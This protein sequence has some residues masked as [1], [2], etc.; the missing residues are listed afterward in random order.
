MKRAAGLLSLLHGA[1]S[2]EIR[3]VLA[4]DV[5]LAGSQVVLGRRRFPVPLDP[6]TLDALKA[7]LA[8]RERLVTDNPHLMVTK[9]SRMHTRPCS[10]YYLFHLFD[11]VGVSP[12]VLRQTRLVHVAH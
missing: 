9:D 4:Q 6:V 8:A 3:N 2:Y 12:Q 7:C 1:S 5:D 10:Q 11:T